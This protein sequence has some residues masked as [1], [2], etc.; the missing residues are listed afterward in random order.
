LGLGSAIVFLYH[1]KEY[2]NNRKRQI[3]AA[4]IFILTVPLIFNISTDPRWSRLIETIPVAID[5]AEDDHWI[6]RRAPKP[7]T[8][9]GHVVTGSN[10][11][12]IVYAIKSAKFII[13][14]PMGVGFGR[15]A[16]GHALELRHPAAWKKRGQ[17]SHSAIL[18]L[19]LGAG[20]IGT[21][22]WLYFVFVTT[23]IAVKEFQSSN[24]YFAIL[25]LFLTMGFVGRG[26]V[27]ANM[28]DHMFLQFM[29]ILGISILFMIEEKNKAI[30]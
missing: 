5:S 27:D 28:R 4:L 29:L 30:E 3:S 10:Y 21:S 20:I 17:H 2:S 16:F 22:L 26:L 15:N 6:D 12:R 1:N 19:T 13:D 8:E 23:R 24:N 11:S 18:E 14:E 25:V 9:S 7:V